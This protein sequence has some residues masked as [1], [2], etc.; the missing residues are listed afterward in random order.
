[1]LQYVD[2]YAL[3]DMAKIGWKVM[4]IEKLY[5]KES[6]LILVSSSHSGSKFFSL[7]V[8]WLAVKAN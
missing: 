2:V 7:V 4:K 1:M 8:A 6:Y 5:L 3:L